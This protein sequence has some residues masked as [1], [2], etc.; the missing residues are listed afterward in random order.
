MRIIAML[1]A[2]A[3]LASCDRAQEE[4]E[5]ATPATP[6]ALIFDG[7][8]YAGEAAK[9]AH[10]KR[11]ARVLDCT[12]CHE[13]DLQGR[14]V[15]A[16][17][18]DYGDMWAPNL[19]LKLADYNDSDIERLLRTGT[20]KDGRE[21]WFMPAESYQFL[22]TPDLAALI[23]FLRSFKPAG[24]QVPADPQGPWLPKGGRGGRLRPRRRPDRPPARQSAGRPGARARARADAGADRLH[25]LP[26][27]PARGLHRLHAR[28]RHRRR[29]QPG[30]AR[31][32]A[33]HRQGQEQAQPRPDDQRRAL[34]L[35]AANPRR[36]PG[37]RRLC[38]RARQPPAAAAIVFKSAAS[39]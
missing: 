13:D 23:A 21:L 37:D 14:N 29:L 8:D 31:D 19:T 16:D 26:Q 9:I 2:L 27:R 4:R 7:A 38:P 18:P 30:G 17:D 3:A 22:S 1:A 20:P 11:L 5:A 6:A 24:K 28:P 10:G 32:P 25:R 39:R 34:F 35:F 12:G 33:H 15:T 36:A